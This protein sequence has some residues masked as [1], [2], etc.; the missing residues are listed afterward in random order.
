[1]NQPNFLDVVAREERPRKRVR[2]VSKAVYAELRDSERL[3]K[4]EA[5][6]LRELAAYYNRR[7]EWPTVGELTAWMHEHRD[8]P[9]N[10]TRLVAP[11]MTAL[12]RT[13]RIV[14]PLPARPCAVLGSK[15]HGWRVTEAGAR[16]LVGV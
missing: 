5:D 16:H 15:A 14:E 11:R 2:A 6:V 9:R 7:A 3:S 8:I 1:M 10:D 13:H 12:C 4:R